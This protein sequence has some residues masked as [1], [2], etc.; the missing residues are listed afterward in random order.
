MSVNILIDVSITV[1]KLMTMGK[2]DLLQDLQLETQ[3]KF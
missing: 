1:C 2:H 3:H